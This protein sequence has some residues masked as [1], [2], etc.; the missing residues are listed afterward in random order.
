MSLRDHS[1]ASG[2]RSNL[3]GVEAVTHTSRIATSPD[4]IGTPR[5]DLKTTNANIATKSHQ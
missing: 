3:C 4:E 2:R 1:A 5:N